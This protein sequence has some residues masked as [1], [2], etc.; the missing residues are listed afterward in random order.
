[1][2]SGTFL[3]QGG[4]VWKRASEA[5][6]PARGMYR[7]P[8]GRE[9]T[10]PGPPR[11]VWGCERSSV[12]SFRGGR[13]FL[14]GAGTRWPE[15]VAEFRDGPPGSQSEGPFRLSPRHPLAT[16]FHLFFRVSA[17]VTYVCCDW[18]SKSFVGGFVTVLLLLS[19][20]FWSVKVRPLVR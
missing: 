19:L 20:D 7:V 11:R 3:F 12:L 8:G 17:I 15:A 13:T 10:Q 4:L 6:R 16:F 2:T 14:R 5:R 18:F 1:M 9:P